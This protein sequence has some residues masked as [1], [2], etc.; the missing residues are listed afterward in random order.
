MTMQM[1]ISKQ[2]FTQCCT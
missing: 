1:V 2:Y